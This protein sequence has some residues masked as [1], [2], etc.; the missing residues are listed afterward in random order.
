MVA[1][2]T[3]DLKEGFSFVI[4]QAF[5]RKCMVLAA[6]MNLLL[7]PVFVVGAPTI[8]RVTMGVS[9]TLYGIGM[10]SINAATIL[11]ALSIGLVAKKMHTTTIHRWIIAIAILLVPMA[12]TLIPMVSNLGYYPSYFVFVGLSIPVCALLTML[13]I[14]VITWVQRSTP[15]ENLGK[16]MAIVTAVAQCAA[17]LGQVIYG[18]LFERFSIQVYL[19]VF[20][21]AIAMLGIGV[22]AKWMLGTKKGGSADVVANAE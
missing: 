11:G 15:D 16:V 8:L 5:I 18:M 21:A 9:D 3:E 19:P 12:L 6:L 2:I 17:P 4:Q 10:A 22:L 7:T 1:T 20:L 13:S 14:F